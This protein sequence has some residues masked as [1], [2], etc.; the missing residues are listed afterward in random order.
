[1][2]VGKALALIRHWLVVMCNQADGATN[3]LPDVGCISAAATVCV[4]PWSRRTYLLFGQLVL[5]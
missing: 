5:L 2:S 4:I 1:M 3:N